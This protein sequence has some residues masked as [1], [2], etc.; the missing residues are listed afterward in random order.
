MANSFTR[1][2]SRRNAAVVLA[3]LGAGTMATGFLMSENGT[4]AADTKK[5]LYP[6]R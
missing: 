5:K 6:P 4:L 2:M 1:L 3:S